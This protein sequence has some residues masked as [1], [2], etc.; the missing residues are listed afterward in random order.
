M[1]ELLTSEVY[2]RTLRYYDGG[3]LGRRKLGVLVCSCSKRDNK[4]EENEY[5]LYILV[6]RQTNPY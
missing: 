3:V 2:S 1:Y 4:K 5:K 6:R